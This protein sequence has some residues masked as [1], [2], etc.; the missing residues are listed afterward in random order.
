MMLNLQYYGDFHCIESFLLKKTCCQIRQKDGSSTSPRT[1][2][3]PF[4]THQHQQEMNLPLALTMGSSHS[5]GSPQLGFP[6]ATAQSEP[7]LC[8]CLPPLSSPFPEQ[9]LLHVLPRVWGPHLQWKTHLQQQEQHL[10]PNTRV[11]GAK[12]PKAHPFA[13]VLQLPLQM[14]WDQTPAAL[15][16][17]PAHLDLPE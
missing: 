12:K 5:Q 14:G 2:R 8:S 16:H 6:G 10:W 7:L 9:H 4:G 11:W 1:A 13:H 15:L 17:T 3:H